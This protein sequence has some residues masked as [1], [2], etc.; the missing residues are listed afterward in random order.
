MTESYYWPGL[1]EEQRYGLWTDHLNAGGSEL[2]YPVFCDLM[3]EISELA[4][5]V[6]E[7]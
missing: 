7:G 5:Y 1:S 2:P 4:R 6:T 3:D